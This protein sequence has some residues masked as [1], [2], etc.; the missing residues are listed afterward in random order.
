MSQEIINE[1]SFSSDEEFDSEGEDSE[2]S[3][4]VDV[5]V[6]QDDV[7]DDEFF[8][9]YAALKKKDEK[10][11][12]KNVR[13]FSEK[14]S[15]GSDKQ[16]KRKNVKITLLSHQ[17]DLK[18][19]DLELETAKDQV[20]A[21]K[22]FY[23]KELED[24]KKAIDDEIDSD[25]DDELLVVKSSGACG[26]TKLRSNQKKDENSTSNLLNNL[27]VDQSKLSEEEKYL[28]DYIV[29]KRYVPEKSSFFSKNIDEL[30]DVEEDDIGSKVVKNHVNHHSEEK[31]FDKIKRVPRNATKTIRDIVEKRKKKEKRL[32]ILERKKKQKRVIKNADCEDMVGDLPTKFPYIE[33]EPVNYGMTAEEL[34][35]VSDDDPDIVQSKSKKRKKS[36]LKEDSISASVPEATKPSTSASIRRKKKH[37]R[38]VN[39]KKFA[40]VGVAPDRL[41]AY[42]L[43]KTKLRKS[44]LL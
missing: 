19:S 20:V 6:A 23:E 24:I 9:C 35:M 29:N 13:F 15:S 28:R 33:I 5:K 3:T 27:W 4:D 38:G 36:A 14:E 41:L 32:E 10:I 44:K 37:K 25:S 1:D 22:S 8:H 42:G 21:Q 43:S 30:S 40:K 26:N 34:L 7:F 11:Y 31:D 18:E 17:L 16:E 39:H 2:S 12:D